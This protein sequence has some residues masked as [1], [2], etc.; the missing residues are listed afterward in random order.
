MS[1]MYKAI[2]WVSAA[3]S[4]VISSTALAIERTP[5]SEFNE[6]LRQEAFSG[7]TSIL[8]SQHQNI[9]YEGYFEGADNATL[10]NTRSA[11]KTL[12][13]LLT[14][15]AIE[16]GYLKSHYEPIVPLFQDKLTQRHPDPRKLAITFEDMLTMSSLLECNDE[17]T[18]S[19]G[20]EERMYIVEDWAAFT[21]N[22]PIRGFPAWVTKPENS[23]FGRAFS[24]CTA[25]SALLGLALSKLIDG[26]LDVF[27]NTHLF[28]PMGIERVVWQYTPT[29]E[30]S[31][32]GGTQLSTHDLMKLGQLLLNHGQW[33]GKRLISQ[34]WVNQ[35]LTPRAQPRENYGY[36]YQIWQMPFTYQDK[37][38]RVWSM[39][40]NGGN[41]VIVSPELDLVT[42]ITST[43][44]GHAD[45]HRKSQQLFQ[46]VILP[47]LPT[48]Q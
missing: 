31:T 9:L 37:S 47:S 14:G 5:L 38:I 15:I 8:V 4:L 1:N 33:N 44:F 35:M 10:H 46:E 3:V 16:K 29:G 43:N 25:Q 26:P 34:Q 41:Y 19:R 2:Q 7:I 42:V 11:T 27:A 28:K 18:F 39:S 21:V 30:A 36:G 20:H 24:Y 48:S 40:G 6:T 45:G 17:N 13:A 12:V 22:L 32:A 23:P